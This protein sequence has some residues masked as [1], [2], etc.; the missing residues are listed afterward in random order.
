MMS[1]IGDSKKIP[2]DIDSN[3]SMSISKLGNFAKD[4]DYFNSKN[5][6]NSPMRYRPPAESIQ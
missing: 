5:R 3:E 1:L 2:L 4:T 6:N